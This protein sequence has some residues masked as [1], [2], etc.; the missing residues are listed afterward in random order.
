MVA[1]HGQRM[2]KFMI[3]IENDLPYTPMGDWRRKVKYY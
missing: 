2:S 3:E 1:G